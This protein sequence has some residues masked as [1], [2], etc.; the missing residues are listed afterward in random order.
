[1]R[2]DMYEPGLLRYCYVDRIDYEHTT[3]QTT[4]LT[5]SSGSPS[6]PIPAAKA[7]PKTKAK[8]APP[9]KK[10]HDVATA[11]ARRA[12]AAASLLDHDLKDLT[13][14]RESDA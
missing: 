10:A 7:K 6:A 14:T 13:C 3:R 11:D 12:I 4:K 9:K 2:E 5:A 1:M 8:P